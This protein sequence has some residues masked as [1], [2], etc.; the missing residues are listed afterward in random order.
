ML[1]TIRSIP[2]SEPVLAMPIGA[3]AIRILP[4]LTGEDHDT[5]IRDIEALWGAVEGTVA[6]DRLDVLATWVETYESLC[7]PIKPLNPVHAIETAMEMNGHMRPDQPVS[8]G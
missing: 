4:I 6:G 8:G 7:W 5:A 1:S 2:D 3:G